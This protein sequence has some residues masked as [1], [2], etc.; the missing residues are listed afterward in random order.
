MIAADTL[1]LLDTAILLHLLRN[2]AAGRWIDAEYELST[3]AERPLICEVTIGELLRMGARPQR[4]WGAAR[5]KALR[6]WRQNLVVMPIGREPILEAYAE[7]G[8][9]ADGA[10]RTLSDNDVWIA[11][12][13]RVAEAILLTTDRDF[14]PLFPRCIQREW[15][16][17]EFLKRL[18]RDG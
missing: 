8:A 13:T 5:R 4:Q 14:D 1:I 2:R 10:G 17:P 3:R 11:A 6:S 18:N 9:F 7:V 12:C 15:I 16:D